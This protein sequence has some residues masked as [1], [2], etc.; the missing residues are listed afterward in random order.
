MNKEVSIRGCYSKPK[1]VRDQKVLARTAIG[2]QHK[3]VEQIGS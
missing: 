3:C 2:N 1:G